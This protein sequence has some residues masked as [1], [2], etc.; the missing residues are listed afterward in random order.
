M[1]E[2]HSRPKSLTLVWWPACRA[3]PSATLALRLGW[4]LGSARPRWRA[5]RRTPDRDDGRAALAGGIA[6]RA[7]LAPAGPPAS[8][9]PAKAPSNARSCQLGDAMSPLYLSRERCPEEPVQDGPGDALTIDL[10]SDDCRPDD[11]WPQ[12]GAGRAH[13]YR[14]GA[15]A[16]AVDP[17]PASADLALAE[18]R[19]TA[20]PSRP[21][22]RETGC[23]RARSGQHTVGPTA[24]S[25]RH[26]GAVCRRIDV[27]TIASPA[28]RL[29]S[30][31]RGDTLLLDVIPY[32]MDGADVGLK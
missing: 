20:P 28:R 26:R 19:P 5:G 10:D 17:A 27:R 18:G 16:R 25:M 14:S 21:L 29:H 1:R 9:F 8:R 32:W 12:E 22:P 2:R 30:I 4:R 31:H 7:L 11:A 6:L 3:D 24:A 13:G 15:P 23:A